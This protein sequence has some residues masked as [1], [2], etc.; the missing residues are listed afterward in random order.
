MSASGYA[1][2]EQGGTNIQMRRIEQIAR[3][4]DI[5][6]L[7]LMSLGEKKVIYCNVCENNLDNNSVL[8][9][10]TNDSEGIIATSKLQMTV[11]HQAE[12]IELLKKEIEMQKEMIELLKKNQ[13]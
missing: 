3:V 5:S 13:Q 7:E 6:V 1:K 8:V 12:T 2:L 10:V 4:F 9:G 11:N